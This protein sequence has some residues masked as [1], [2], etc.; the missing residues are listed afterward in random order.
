M[1]RLRLVLLA[2]VAVPALDAQNYAIRM[3]TPVHAG[4]TYAV[5]ASGSRLDKTSIGDRVLNSAEYHVNFQGG[6]TILEV[7]GKGRPVKVS[8]TVERL[9]KIEGGMTIDLLKPGNV[10]MADSSLPQPIFLKDGTMEEP[11]RAA[12]QLVYSTHQSGDVTDDEIFGT[13]QAKEVGDSWPINAALASESLKDAGITVAPEHLSGKVSLV[14]KDKIGMVDCLDLSG[15][16]RAQNV[17]LK[18]V[19]PGVT[20]DG[21]SVQAVFRG[22]FPVEISQLSH[23]EGADMLMQMRLTS[24]EGVKADITRSEKRDSVWLAGR[25]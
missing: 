14:G 10:V 20:V 2:V 5:S 15:E 3:S 16:F 19:P 4:Q 9:T 13:E 12:F 7:D 18:Q 1:K 24:K 21:A 23:T 8:F 6:A 22:C 11:V 25:N 17:A